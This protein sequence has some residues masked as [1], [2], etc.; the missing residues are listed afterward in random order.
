MLTLESVS[1]SYGETLIVRDVSL[2][3]PPGQVVCLLGRNGVGKTTLLKS[4][5]GLLTPRSGSI[6]F[7]G[8]ELTVLSP[9]ERA[10]RGIGYVPQRRDIFPDLTVQKKLRVGLVSGII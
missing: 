2:E 1:A 5:M 6:I 3:V 7:H 10:R 9:A 8:Q 4:I